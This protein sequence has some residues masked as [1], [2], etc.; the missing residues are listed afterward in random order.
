MEE[1][2]KRKKV[3]ISLY[4]KDIAELEAGA[5]LTGGNK[6]EY[7]RMLLHFIVPH[8]MPDKM[9]WK[10]MEEPHEIHNSIKDNA[11]GNESVLAACKDLE[12]RTQKAK[13]RNLLQRHWN[14]QYRRR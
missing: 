1:K 5:R 8:N 14:Y 12:Q 7:V 10:R 2:D 13:D 3:T 6:S 11:D 9:L 4:D